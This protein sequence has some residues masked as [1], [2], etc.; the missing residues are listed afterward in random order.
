MVDVARLAGVSAMTVSG[1]FRDPSDGYP[2]NP[3]TRARVQAAAAQLGY[4]PNSVAR[5]MRNRSFHDIGLLVVKPP[6]YL[7]TTPYSMAGVF[8]VLNEKN[9]QLTLIGLPPDISPERVPKS[10]GERCIDSLIVDHTMGVSREI[11][12]VVTAA[13]FPAV[14]LN[15][16]GPVNS[17]HVDDNESCGELTRHLISRGYKRIAFFSYSANHR[18][19]H[20]SFEERRKAYF[21]AMA[22]AGL[23]AREISVPE[24]PQ[25]HLAAAEIF[26]QKP[27]PDAV[28]AYSDFDAVFLQRPLTALG[29]KVPDDVAIATFQTDAFGYS[30][31][32]LT[33]MRIPWYE[34]GRAAA[35]MAIEAAAAG[36]RVELPSRAFKAEIYVGAST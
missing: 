6:R 31:V 22:E 34:M 20:Y 30:T 2:V 27:F 32:D 33:L 5:A 10:L 12:S 36:M 13:A 15:H 11:S 17:V 25:G 16:N 26:R 35:D 18:D 29:L 28:V 7:R 9:Y 1:V 3:E 24:R 19:A 23:A 4:R 8:D 21:I 14:S